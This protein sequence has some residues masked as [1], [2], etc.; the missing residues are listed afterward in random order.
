LGSLGSQI[1]L[2]P[3]R[4]QPSVRDAKPADTPSWYRLDIHTRLPVFL[5]LAATAALSIHILM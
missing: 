1:P 2:P 5:S 4:N 3:G